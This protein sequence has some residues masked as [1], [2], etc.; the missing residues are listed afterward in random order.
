MVLFD[1]G[2]DAVSKLQTMWRYRKHMAEEA[3]QKLNMDNIARLMAMYDEDGSGTID[4]E[5][6]QAL[7][8]DLNQPSADTEVERWFEQMDHDGS[9]EIDVVELFH[10]FPPAIAATMRAQGIFFDDHDGAEEEEKHE[11]S[12]VNI[13]N[14]FRTVRMK[15]LHEEQVSSQRVAAW[16]VNAPTDRYSY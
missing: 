14:A 4:R 1:K 2:A 11:G 5:E 9:G 15:S 10:A 16:G 13:L 3:E 6:L 12:R 7:L 8:Q